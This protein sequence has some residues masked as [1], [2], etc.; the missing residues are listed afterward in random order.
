MCSVL[1][2]PASVRPTNAVP[3]ARQFAYTQALGLER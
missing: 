1:R 2:L 3:L